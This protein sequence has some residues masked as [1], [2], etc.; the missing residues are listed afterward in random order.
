MKL[1]FKVEPT[2]KNW[3]SQEIVATCYDCEQEVFRGPLS[4]EYDGLVEFELLPT[5]LYK[6]ADGTKMVHCE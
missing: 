2:G 3:P 6:W 4:S 5:E 1:Y